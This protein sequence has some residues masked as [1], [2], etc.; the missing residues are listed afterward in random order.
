MHRNDF[1]KS[2]GVLLACTCGTSV[3]NGCKAITGN[4][5]TPLISEN[6]YTINQGYLVLDLDRIPELEPDGGS[7]KLELTSRDLKIIVARTGKNSFVALR[8]QCTHGGREVEYKHDE[9][10]FRC[11][12]F[13]H[14]KYGNSGEVIKGP[15][16]TGLEKFTTSLVEKKLEIK[17][18]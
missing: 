11:V 15:A 18:V 13:G 14:S 8:D 6:A 17:L 10:I 4:S 12:S 2:G 3:L 5:D 16:K 7:V 1:L 9:S